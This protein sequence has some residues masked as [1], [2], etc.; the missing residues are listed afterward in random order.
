MHLAIINKAEA[1]QTLWSNNFPLLH[2]VW[3]TSFCVKV[4]K[5]HGNINDYKEKMDK[6]V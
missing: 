2:A 1:L 4:K 3:D 6:Y 5:N